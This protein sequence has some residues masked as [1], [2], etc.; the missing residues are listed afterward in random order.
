LDLGV[1]RY[2]ARDHIVEYACDLLI[3]LK[4]VDVLERLSK[5]LIDG[6]RRYDGWRRRQGRRWN[7]HANPSSVSRCRV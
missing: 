4:V 7:G 1:L 6:G 5:D 2:A 3:E